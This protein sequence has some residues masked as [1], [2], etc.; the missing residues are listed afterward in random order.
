VIGVVAAEAN[1]A[2]CLEASDAAGIPPFQFN[3]VGDVFGLC[4][5]TT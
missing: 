2:G 4:V 3:I 1:M 5:P